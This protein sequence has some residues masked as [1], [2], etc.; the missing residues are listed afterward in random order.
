[1][2]NYT[3]YATA[4]LELQCYYR[5]SRKNTGNDRI[6]G[7]LGPRLSAP[8]C[9]GYRRAN[10]WPTYARVF[11]ELQLMATRNVAQVTELQGLDCAMVA[12]LDSLTRNAL[13]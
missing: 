3:T 6:R 1:M 5:Y 12:L 8:V 11:A 2:F 4:H 13:V 10:M 7:P 9:A